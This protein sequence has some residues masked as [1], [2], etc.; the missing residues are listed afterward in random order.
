MMPVVDE[1]TRECLDIEVECSIT[2][3]D[4]IATR[5]VYSRSEESHDTFARTTAPS[6][7]RRCS[8]GG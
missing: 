3:E 2:S 4:E 5:R 1:Y 7:W 8:K 6:S